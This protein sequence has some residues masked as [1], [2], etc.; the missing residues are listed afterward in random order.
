M[1]WMC[2]VHAFVQAFVAQ[3]SELTKH[4]AEDADVDVPAPVQDYL[5]SLVLSSLFW[6]R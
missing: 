5:A 2:C 3:C 6:V 4:L 1:V